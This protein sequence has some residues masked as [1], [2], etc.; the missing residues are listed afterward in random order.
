MVKKDRC[1][2]CDGGDVE[3]SKCFIS[4]SE[5]FEQDRQELL[6]RVR[7]IVRAE[8]LVTVFMRKVLMT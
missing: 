8:V 5:E 4:E 1:V 3:D 7:R 2:L 6:G